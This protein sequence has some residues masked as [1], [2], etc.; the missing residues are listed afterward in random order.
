VWGLSSLGDSSNGTGETP[1]YHRITSGNPLRFRAAQ[2]LSAVG[3][4]GQ[5]FMD[6]TDIVI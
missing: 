3:G 4:V 5:F 2:L 6:T 1:S